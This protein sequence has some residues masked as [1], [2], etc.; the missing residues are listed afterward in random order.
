MNL[1]LDHAPRDVHE[2]VA[3]RIG[4][5]EFAVDIAFVHEIRGWVLETA[6]PHAP[7]YIR[8]V[9]NLRGSV[10]P[11]LDLAERL[12]LAKACPTARHVIMIVNVG[13]QM[14]GLLVDEVSGIQTVKETSFRPLPKVGAGLTCQFVQ[15]ILAVDG[16]MIVVLALDEVFPV[17]A[18]MSVAA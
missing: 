11:I 6:L 7:H 5:Q 3:F 17:D 15:S 9:I 16:R 18:D 4:Q 8:G 10:L 14:L 1:T 13:S 2:L 12:R